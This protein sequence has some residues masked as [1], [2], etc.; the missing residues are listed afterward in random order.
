[1]KSGLIIPKRFC[2]IEVLNFKI[3]KLCQDSGNNCRE[4]DN[5]VLLHVVIFLQLSKDDEF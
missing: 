2:F 5:T 4:N 1:M 3:T